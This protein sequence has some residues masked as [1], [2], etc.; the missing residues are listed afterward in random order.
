MSAEDRP[1]L[2][3]KATIDDAFDRL[4]NAMFPG[5]RDGP[6]PRAS[7]PAQPDRD[8]D[9]ILGDALTELYW[10]REEMDR[11]PKEEPAMSA[12]LR[13]AV[14]FPAPNPAYTSW[15]SCTV[16]GMDFLGQGECGACLLV[17]RLLGS[18]DRLLELVEDLHDPE[19]CWYDH[20]GYCQAHGWMATEP[21]CPHARAQRLLRPGEALHNAHLS[22]ESSSP[23]D[24]ES[25][26]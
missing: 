24:Q 2:R 20:H 3:D 22:P 1:P 5:R 11:P 17:R 7:I 19:P 12:S 9:L 25:P 26:R 23:G 8:T 10:R 16:E 4:L 21:P 18:E 15:P 13:P 14:S 6:R